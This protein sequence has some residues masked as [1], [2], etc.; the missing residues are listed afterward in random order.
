VLSAVKRDFSNVGSNI[1][2]FF[3]VI[4]NKAGNEYSGGSPVEIFTENP[5]LNRI[6]PPPHKI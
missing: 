1:K 2:D 3:D 4:T 6:L 5:L